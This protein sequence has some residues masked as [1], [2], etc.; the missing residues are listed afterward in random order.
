MA[1]PAA[2]PGSRRVALVTG[3]ARGIGAAT[4]A[5]LA[6]EGYAV[7]A[8]DLAPGPDHGLPG[9]GYPLPDRS[10]LD[11]VAAA[12]D[13]V[14]AHVAD[15]RDAAA[16]R[17]AVARAVEAWGRL[18]VV[19]AGAAVLSGGRPLWEHD[20]LAEQ[21]STGVAGVWHTVAAAVPAMLAGPDP[22]GCRVVAI[23]SVA[24][25]RGLFHL[26]GYTT[27]KHAVVGL[28]RGLAADLAG[29]G[30][31]AVAVAPG[32]AR[33]PLLSATAAL[34]G[35]PEEELGEH[36]LVGEVLDPDEVAATIAFCSSVE[37]R[38]LNGSVVAADGG[39][40]G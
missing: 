32:A 31:T 2:G 1:G 20:A 25:T 37:G 11:A 33:T 36:Q 8:V 30:V 23:A 21:W 10:D 22:S 3:A 38:V 13:D 26:A 4:V 39:F 35:V 27:V 17:A 29:T 40:R 24:G 12:H 34:Y 14:E 16:M 15:V 7:L 28:V 5:A 19:V 9:V 18:D 6:A